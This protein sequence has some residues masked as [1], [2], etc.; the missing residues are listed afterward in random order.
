[1]E[2]LLTHPFKTKPFSHQLEV[3]EQSRDMASFA[4]F[5]EQGTGKTKL[6]IDTLAAQF[7]E[8]RVDCLLVVAP[9]GVD[10]NWITDELP[11]HLPDEIAQQMMAV[12]YRSQKAQTKWHQQELSQ[13]VHHKGL[14]VLTISYDAFVTNAG[15]AFAWRLMKSR[16]I[17]YVLDE[18]HAIKTPSA[19]RTKAILGS[20]KYAE[21]RRILTGTPVAQGPFDIYS[22]MRFL[23][24]EFWSR[25]GIYT[26]TAFKRHFGVWEVGYGNGRQF[27]VLKEYKNLDELYE[28][29]QGSSSRVLKEDVL[30]LPPKLYSKRYFEMSREQERLYE[31]LSREFVVELERPGGEACSY[32]AGRGIIEQDAGEWGI[33]EEPCASCGGSGVESD[34][35]DADLAIVR[36][37]RLQQITCGYLPVGEDGEFRDLDARNNRL[38]SLL[39][40]TEGTPH[41]AIIWARFSRDIDLI[42]DALGGRAVRYDGQVD[43]DE[44]ERSKNAFQRGDA[45]WFVGNPAKGATGLTLHAAQSV[46][47]YNNNFKLIDRL[48]SEDRAH[49]IGQ[50]HPVN[51]TDMVALF[52]D[53]RHTVDNNI[54]KALREKLQIS[55]LITGDRLKDWL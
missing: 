5:W 28:I 52:Q 25:R 20:S 48:Q 36:L 17:F 41:K 51:Y 27:D 45:Q 37:L 10:R 53:G 55:S 19:K 21:T 40:W 4:V 18:A 24:P 22:Q 9:S 50:E 49:R 54:V 7:L 42:M 12:N 1:M 8:G 13:L 6:V 44:A 43:D 29:L 16:K 32:C 34:I 30:D 14:S 46:H 26:F 31:Q 38:D 11:A 23:D 2:S 39:E 3:W 33:L 47:Y 35:V 15:K